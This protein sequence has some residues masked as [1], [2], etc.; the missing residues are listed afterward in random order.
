MAAG[1]VSNVRRERG[2]LIKSPVNTTGP[3]YGGTIMGL[4]N[5]F[6]FA[7]GI[8]YARNYFD[9]MAR[10]GEIFAIQKDAAFRFKLRDMDEDA[11]TEFFPNYS[12][13]RVSIGSGQGPLMA[14]K[15]ARYLFV[16][17]NPTVG[18][19]LLLL[20]AVPLIEASETS[21]RLSFRFE[22]QVSVSLLAAPLSA[23]DGEC[24]RLGLLADLGI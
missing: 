19:S 13:S 11:I 1:Q 12:S 17:D 4:C 7:T 10:T 3:D 8:V 23:T 6:K 2:T 16:S 14:T 5:G 22:T 9:E 15:A 21:L 24:A 20:N 18:Q